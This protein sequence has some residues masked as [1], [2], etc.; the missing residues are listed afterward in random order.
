MLDI[1]KF[2]NKTQKHLADTTLGYFSCPE[3]DHM[4]TDH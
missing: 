2:K 4:M 3:C 1:L